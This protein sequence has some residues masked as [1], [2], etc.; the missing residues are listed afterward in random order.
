M[1]DADPM[2]GESG[3]PAWLIIFAIVAVATLVKWAC[4]GQF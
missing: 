4:S 3:S 2:G 1:Q